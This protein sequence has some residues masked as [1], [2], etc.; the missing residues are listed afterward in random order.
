MIHGIAFLQ[1]PYEIVGSKETGEAVSGTEPEDEAED[2]LEIL[3]TPPGMN[4]E[5]F[6]QWIDV[7]ADVQ[8][9]RETTKAEVTQ[10]LVAGIIA[11]NP[12][13]KEQV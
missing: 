13:E 5:E 6:Q 3:P 11:F 7:N 2:A 10:E 1:K 9:V 4:A 12:K 8:V